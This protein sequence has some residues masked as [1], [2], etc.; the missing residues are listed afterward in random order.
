MFFINA[1]QT[2]KH[3]VTHYLSSKMDICTG[4]FMKPLFDN[5]SGSLTFKFAKSRGAIHYHCI[6]CCH[7]ENNTKL[8]LILKLLTLQIHYGLEIVNKHIAT[9]YVAETHGSNFSLR[10]N[11][12][13]NVKFGEPKRQLF[14]ELNNDVV[15]TAVCKKYSNN[16]T[17]S[18][19]HAE[20]QLGDIFESQ[21]GLE[22]MHTGKFPEECLN[23]GGHPTGY[24]P[25]TRENMQTSINVL[26]KQELRKPKHAR[27]C[28]ISEIRVNILNHYLCHRCCGYFLNKKQMPTI[29]KANNNGNVPSELKF[30]KSEGTDMVFTI[31]KEFR[32]VFGAPF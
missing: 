16:K 9:T 19:L 25:H 29:F 27:E 21:H 12:I 31:Y 23:P 5:V 26:D 30:Y 4:I 10:P 13:N 11:N 1:V 17:N 24:Y 18:I 15:G 20:E 3:V 32:M 22:S 14:C 6:M 8:S 28:H 2:Y 7:G